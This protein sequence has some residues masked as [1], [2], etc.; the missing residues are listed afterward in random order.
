[1][2]TFKCPYCGE[3]ITDNDL[4]CPKCGRS[5]PKGEAR[6]KFEA[7]MI[8]QEAK[9]RK[10][11]Y[12]MLAVV[13]ISVFAFTKFTDNRNP[14]NASSQSAQPIHEDKADERDAFF[15][16]H[17]FVKKELVAPSSAKF[18]WFD[19]SMVRQVNED[20]WVINSY[21]DSQNRFGAML[22]IDY[23]AKIQYLGNDMWRCLDLYLHER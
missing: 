7:D 4:D 2:G 17:K 1:M 14:T 22:R 18:P 8:E 5:F 11:T 6:K 20:T 19:K 10:T 16:S 13:L 15:M 3:E 21:V 12:I 9:D 23:V